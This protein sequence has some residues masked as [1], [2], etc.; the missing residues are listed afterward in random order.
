MN[1]LGN[2]S[3]ASVKKLPFAGT[4]TALLARLRF[5][6]DTL[7]KDAQAA[8]HV[9]PGEL[10]LAVIR[11][12]VG[13]PPV[14]EHCSYRQLQAHESPTDVLAGLGPDLTQL[15]CNGLVELST[16]SLLLVEKPDVPDA[17]LAAAMRWR[18]KDL[19]DYPVDEAVVDVFEVP[20]QSGGG[21]AAMTYVVVARAAAVKNLADVLLDAG[22]AL[23]NIDIPELALRNVAALLPEDISGVA[24]VHLGP[25]RGLITL[26]RQA[27]LYMSR[28]IDMGSDVLLNAGTTTLTS[29]IEARLDTIVIEVQ[30]SLDY[31]DR[32]FAQAPIGTLVLAPLP[33]PVAGICEYLGSQLGLTVR[34]LDLNKVVDSQTPLS[35]EV[36]AHCFATVGAALRDDEA[37]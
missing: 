14:L 10:A 23:R 8:L 15:P 27:T 24:L 16:Y 12:E 11:R 18:V 36:Q 5:G 30:R 4:G 37:A 19:I 35:N 7:R 32:H 22:A 9:V 17:E 28:R 21:Q 33:Q 3:P 2:N 34:I 6:K 31:Y 1:A 29:E 26:S 25:Q 20:P 13:V